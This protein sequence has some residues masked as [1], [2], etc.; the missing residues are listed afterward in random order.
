MF[1]VIGPQKNGAPLGSGT[2]LKYMQ[3]D[4]SMVERRYSS[5][6]PQ[7]HWAYFILHTL[8]CSLLLLHALWAASQ[9]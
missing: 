8:S 1:W 3:T 5:T 2:P 9:S 6:Q 4:Q 7:E